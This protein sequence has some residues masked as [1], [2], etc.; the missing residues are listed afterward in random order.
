MYSCPS[1]GLL[2]PRTLPALTHRQR[3]PRP[4]GVRRLARADLRQLEGAEDYLTIPPLVPRG[5]VGG[6][7][8]SKK[9][10]FSS[11]VMNSA[12]FFHT[13]GLDTIASTTW[14]V[15]ISPATGLEKSGCSVCGRPSATQDTCGRRLAAMSA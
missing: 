6:F 13:S 1:F 15:P 12:V 5:A 7:T 3:A 10:P 2:D 8:W 14:R 4:G 11:Q 9:P